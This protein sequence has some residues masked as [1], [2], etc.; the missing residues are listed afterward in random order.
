MR[1]VFTLAGGLN[2]VIHRGSLNALSQA[3][4]RVDETGG[5]ARARMRAQ[6][7]GGLSAQPKR[8]P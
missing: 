6:A 1:N 4:G 7:A 3:F 2:G 8:S 5:V